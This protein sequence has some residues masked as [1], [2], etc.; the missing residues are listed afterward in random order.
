MRCKRSCQATRRWLVIMVKQPR[1]GRAKTRLAR[2]AGIAQALGFYRKTMTAVIARTAADP[3]WTAV[4]A[5]TPDTARSDP[6]WPHNLPRIPQGAGDLGH[7]MHRAFAALPPGPAVLIGSDI[8]AV[9]AHHIATAFRAL[10]DHDAVFGPAPDGGYWL[11][12]LSRRKPATQCFAN[13][14]W[15]SAH[16]LADTLRSMRDF[17]IATIATLGDVDSCA[18]LA[19]AAAWCG[20]RVLPVAHGDEY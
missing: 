15:S 19:R 4:L 8:P 20:R 7:R 14:R 12:G 9:R 5:I 3:R 17:D 11:V 16:T 10:G 1:A 13:V 18:D 2:D 6:A